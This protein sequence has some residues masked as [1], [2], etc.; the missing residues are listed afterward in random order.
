LRSQTARLDWDRW[1]VMGLIGFSVGI[2]GFLLHQ[3]IEFISRTKWTMANTLLDQQ[4]VGVAF[5][6]VLGFSMALLLPAAAVVV[7]FRF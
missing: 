7:Y 4:G 5:L 6:W 3:S 1:V 2:L